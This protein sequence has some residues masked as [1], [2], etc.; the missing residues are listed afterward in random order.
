MRVVIGVDAVILVGVAAFAG[1]VFRTEVERRGRIDKASDSYRATGFTIIETS[2][3]GSPGTLEYTPEKGC[4]IAVSTGDA[5]IRVARA[6]GDTIEG[7]GPVVFCTCA[8]EKLT[9]TSKVDKEGGLGLLRI[10]SPAVGG[11]KAFAFLSFK[12]GTTARTDEACVEQTFDAWI[13]GKRYP[14]PPPVDEKWLK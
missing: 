5:P 2:G 12:P 14:A 7:K 10:E 1:S 6:S 4:L 3:R 8:S 9:V 13:D 11:S